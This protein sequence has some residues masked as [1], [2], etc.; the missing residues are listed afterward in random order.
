MDHQVS[1]AL[2]ALSRHGLAQRRHD[3]TRPGGKTHG[4]WAAQDAGF[5]LIE[6][7]VVISIL[8]V[9]AVG[10]SFAVARGSATAAEADRAWFQ[11]RFERIHD[12]AIAGRQTLG[13]RV[14][15]EGLALARPDPQGGWDRAAPARG[16]QGRVALSRVLPPRG[17]GTD[18][19]DI[20]LHPNGHSSAFD[21]QFT[22]Q[23]GAA[24]RCASDGWTGLTC[25]E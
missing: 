18:R 13:L 1:S 11:T 6:L 14:T 17:A 10:A 4:G 8:A 5:T 15:P 19:P 7:L 21:I 20:L 22:G 9:L 2:C 3:G 24:L 25:A 12:R 16:W 23:R